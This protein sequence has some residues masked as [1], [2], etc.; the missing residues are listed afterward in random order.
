MVIKVDV[1][2]ELKEELEGSG[3]DLSNLVREVIISKAFEM[4]LAKSKALQRAIFEAIINKSK[5]SEEDAKELADKVNKGTWQELKK[6]FP[7]L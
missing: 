5:L 1:S 2:E 3:I 4:H 7:K 6:E